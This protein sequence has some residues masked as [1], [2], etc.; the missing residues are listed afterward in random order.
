MIDWDKQLLSKL[1]S[2]QLVPEV[3]TRFKDDITI[4]I[5]ALEKGSKLVDGGVVVDE[6]KKLVDE[7]KTDNKITMDIIQEISNSINPM[8]K[9]TVETP[10]NFA[11]KMLPVL[12]VKV[13]INESENYRI[14]FNFF[15]KETKINEI[16]KLLQALLSTKQCLT[17]ILTM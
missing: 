16:E 12:D 9:L 7:D 5:E 8:I 13:K 2:Y 6:S 4:V 14:D 3:Y 15:E 1:K 10:C 17:I 11:D